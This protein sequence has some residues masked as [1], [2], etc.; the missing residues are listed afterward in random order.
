MFRIMSGREPGGWASA[1]LTRRRSTVRACAASHPVG[2][3]Q[4][5][6]GDIRVGGDRPQQGAVAV[7]HRLEGT[8]HVPQLTGFAMDHPVLQVDPAAG[9]HHPAVSRPGRLPVLGQHQGVHRAHGVVGGID[10]Q[11][12]DQ[13]IVDHPTADAVV[14]K[15]AD[16]AEALHLLEEGPAGPVG[17]HVLAQR[18]TTDDGAVDGRNGADPHPILPAVDRA[19]VLEIP[20]L[21]GQRRPVGIFQQRHRRCGENLGDQPAGQSAGV[22]AA[23]FE[24]FTTGDQ[25]SKVAVEHQHTHARQVVDQLPISQFA[26]GT[27]G[28]VRQSRCDITQ[29]HQE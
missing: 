29:L 17:G 3:R 28:L 14:G 12:S 16:I 10:T 6:L 15:G 20:F 8:D 9:L 7:D 1:S 24:H 5:R 4:H 26:V 22:E 23:S 21:A 2:L 27:G 19:A 13:F 11:Q 25:Q 18:E